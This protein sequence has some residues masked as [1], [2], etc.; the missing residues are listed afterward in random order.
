M[1]LLREFTAPANSSVKTFVRLSYIYGFLF[2]ILIVK[3]EITYKTEN[4]NTV[5]YVLLHWNDFNIL[6]LSHISVDWAYHKGENCLIQ[7]NNCFK[8]SCILSW[9]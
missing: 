2:A 8:L 3:K 7:L 5:T 6:I 1:H 9:Y 4:T